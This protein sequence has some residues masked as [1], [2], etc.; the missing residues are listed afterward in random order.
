MNVSRNWELSTWSREW[1]LWS[2]YSDR[3]LQISLIVAEFLRSCLFTVWNF[4]SFVYIYLWRSFQLLRNQ[5]LFI[6]LSLKTLLLRFILV[7]VG[8]NNNFLHVDLHQ[9]ARCIIL[10]SFSAICISFPHH[11]FAQ[12]SKSHILAHC[13]CL[14]IIYRLV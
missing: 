11:L 13:V 4:M 1:T 3:S 5:C 10:L 8:L 6:N 14:Y 9:Q 2:S 7:K 12:R